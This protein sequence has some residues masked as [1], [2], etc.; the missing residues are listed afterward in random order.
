MS[1]KV[2]IASVTRGARWQ[3]ETKGGEGF[4]RGA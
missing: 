1:E 2:R 4:G 3:P